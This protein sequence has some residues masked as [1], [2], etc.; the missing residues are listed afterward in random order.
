MQATITIPVIDRFSAISQIAGMLSH[1][2]IR[3]ELI[4]QLDAGK[5]AGTTVAAALRISTPRVTEM[6]KRDRRVQP[7][8]MAPLAR[9]L[10]LDGDDLPEGA[11]PTR[12][13]PLLGEV[14]AG[15]WKEAVRKSHHT[16]PAPEQGLPQTAYALR[17]VGDSMNRVAADG[18]T[19]IVDPTDRD[20]FNNSLFVVG[21]R[22]E[23]TFKQY[24]DGPR[25]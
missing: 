20:L 13:I 16:I 6:K 8:E 5:I 10:G 25:G 11:G 22:G 17:I 15:N 18:A 2:E 23:T 12:P 1:D 9:L 3:E 14:P 19:I 7:D 24:L 4:R 21:R